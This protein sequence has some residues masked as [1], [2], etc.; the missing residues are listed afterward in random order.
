M[1]KLFG[2]SLFMTLWSLGLS[3]WQAAIVPLGSIAIVL[4]VRAN[5]RSPD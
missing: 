1:L 2:P 3:A 5:A 4:Y